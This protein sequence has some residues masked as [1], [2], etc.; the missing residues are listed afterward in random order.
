MAAGDYTQIVKFLEHI[1]S[2]RPKKFPKFFYYK[3]DLV[4]LVL[5]NK[6]FDLPIVLNRYKNHDHLFIQFDA[7]EKTALF[8]AFDIR[9]YTTG[10]HCNEEHGAIDWNTIENSFMRFLNMNLKELSSSSMPYSDVAG[11]TGKTS[12]VKTESQKTYGPTPAPMYE[13]V[14]GHHRGYRR[15]AA[16]GQQSNY[17]YNFNSDTYK[18]RC[19]FTDKLE[20]YSK[21][22]KTSAATEFISVEMS[23]LIEDKNYDVI[24][25]IFRYV[26]IDK[27][28]LLTMRAMLSSTSSLTKSRGRDEFLEKFKTYVNK[29]KPSMANGI[30]KGIEQANV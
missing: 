21:E 26:F 14:Y 3:S 19:A 22:Y 16:H 30:L 7:N 12:T 29:V 27:M 5:A 20:A 9:E 17:G 8:Y 15:Y 23:K 4:C 11:T 13:H 25:A 1:G 28:N 18:Q 6:M 24:D 10:E 2:H